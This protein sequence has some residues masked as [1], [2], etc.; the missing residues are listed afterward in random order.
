MEDLECFL[1]GVIPE[2]GKSMVI[3]VSG[4]PGAEG[5]TGQTGHVLVDFF[6]EAEGANTTS[7][8]QVSRCV[9]VVPGACT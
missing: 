7:L 5:Q 8:F 4:C 6:G 3:V 1:A 9:F 2:G